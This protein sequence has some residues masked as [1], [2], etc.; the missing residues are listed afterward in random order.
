MTVLATS[1]ALTGRGGTTVANGTGVSGGSFGAFSRDVAGLTA[2]RIEGVV[3][4]VRKVEWRDVCVLG[5]R[6]WELGGWC[7]PCSSDRAGCL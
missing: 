6:S 1:V 7:S 3:S 2:L 4:E 5:N